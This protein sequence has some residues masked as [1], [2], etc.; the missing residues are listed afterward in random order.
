MKFYPNSTS[1]VDKTKQALKTIHTS[2]SLLRSA[3]GCGAKKSAAW[4]C[5]GSKF[6]AEEY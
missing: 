2:L 4:V 3:V 5:Y 6:Q 1:N